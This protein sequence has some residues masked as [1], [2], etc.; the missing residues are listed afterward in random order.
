MKNLSSEDLLASVIESERGR[1]EM[2]SGI[3]AAAINHG[4]V[5]AAQLICYGLVRIAEAI[6]EQRRPNQ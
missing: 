6:Q 1:N 5:Y 2:V 4:L 3:D